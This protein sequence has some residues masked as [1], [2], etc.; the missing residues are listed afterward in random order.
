MFSSCGDISLKVTSNS[1]NIA[2][3]QI[4]RCDDA[5]ILRSKLTLAMMIFC[6]H[7]LD[8]FRI[9]CVVIL[10]KGVHAKLDLQIFNGVYTELL[11]TSYHVISINEHYFNPEIFIT[12]KCA[13][14]WQKSHSRAE[15]PTLV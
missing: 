7:T 2:A 13:N 3:G 1:W 8:L 12:A 15:T 10:N 5:T 14:I 4:I 6:T 11:S 9:L